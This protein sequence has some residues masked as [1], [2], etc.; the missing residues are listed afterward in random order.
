MSILIKGIKMP[1]CCDDCPC[2]H[3]TESD[4]EYCWVEPDDNLVY[5][6]IEL[7]R[8]TRPDWCPL[9]E[10]KDQEGEDDE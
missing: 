9:V 8:T 6:P 2:Y 3:R 1:D 7:M 4:N 5:T 10:V